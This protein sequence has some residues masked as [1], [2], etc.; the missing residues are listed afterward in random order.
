MTRDLVTMNLFVV[1]GV[2]TVEPWFA[3]AVSATGSGRALPGMEAG[4]LR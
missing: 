3:S 2:N 1:F 4:E